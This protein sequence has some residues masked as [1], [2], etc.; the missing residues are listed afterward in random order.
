[1]SHWVEG[2]A[3]DNISKNCV[4]LPRTC[5]TNLVNQVGE[6]LLKGYKSDR[7]V[8]LFGNGGKRGAREIPILPARTWARARYPPMAEK[9]FE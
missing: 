6:V 5:A 2:D 9:G 7:T 3:K 1:M 8:Y 4:K